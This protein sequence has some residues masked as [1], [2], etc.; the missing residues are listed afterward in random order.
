[1]RTKWQILNERRAKAQAA[2][3]SIAADFRWMERTVFGRP[4]IGC[5]TMLETEA[6]FAQH[7]V[8]PDERYLNLGNC[9][10]DKNTI[11]E[12]PFADGGTYT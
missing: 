12:D 4:C 5:G 3:D 6:D 10:I 1:M 11:G 7:F 8:I 2:A 9:P